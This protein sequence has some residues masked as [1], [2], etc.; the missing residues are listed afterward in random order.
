MREELMD[1]YDDI[2]GVCDGKGMIRDHLG[3]HIYCTYCSGSGI[4]ERE[5]ID[6]IWGRFPTGSWEREEDQ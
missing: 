3:K 2:C 4:I 5:L 6:T 1:E